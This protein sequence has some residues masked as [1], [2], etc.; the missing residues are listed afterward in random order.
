M[1]DAL[2][3]A[4]ARAICRL[5]HTPIEA[6]RA[7][8]AAIE[9]SGWAVVPTAPTDS[10]IAAAKA[11]NYAWPACCYDVMLSARPRVGGGE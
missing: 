6:A 11:N 3:E 2:I 1:T 10:M 7:A 5:D 4:V 9:A 8:L